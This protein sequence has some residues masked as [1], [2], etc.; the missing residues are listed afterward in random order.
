MAGR[1]PHIQTA[2]S[3]REM[4]KAVNKFSFSFARHLIIFKT[5][6]QN[7]VLFQETLQS[8]LCH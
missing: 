3:A 5:V 2:T 1:S 4:T 6:G 8:N 7:R